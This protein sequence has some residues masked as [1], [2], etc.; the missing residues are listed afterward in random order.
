MAYLPQ[1]RNVL[2]ISRRSIILTEFSAVSP[3]SP[4]L[5]SLQQKE[6]NKCFRSNGVNLVNDCNQQKINDTQ[7]WEGGEL[8]VQFLLCGR[9]WNKLGNISRYLQ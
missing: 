7:G 2:G 8:I 6:K 1:H 4:T 3:T 5:F 9:S